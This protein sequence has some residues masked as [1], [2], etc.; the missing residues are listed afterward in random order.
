MV[1]WFI[2]KHVILRTLR[3]TTLMWTKWGWYDGDN[4]WLAR[5]Y[6][7]LASYLGLVIMVAAGGYHTLG[8][9][10]G[11]DRY[12]ITE[13]AKA[14]VDYSSFFFKHFT[15]LSW[16]NELFIFPCKKNLY[17]AKLNFKSTILSPWSPHGSCRLHWDAPAHQ[18]AWWSSLG[19]FYWHFVM[20]LSTKLRSVSMFL[21]QAWQYSVTSSCKQTTDVKAVLVLIFSK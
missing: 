12:Q 14:M 8:L 13:K 1:E 3:W 10:S 17:R 2:S 21:A 11:R 7:I 16:E 20:T 5:G 18:G 9:T 6:H 15:F 4:G 19:T